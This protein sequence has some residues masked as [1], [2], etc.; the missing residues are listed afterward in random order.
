MITQNWDF[1]IKGW[2]YL[3]I[4]FEHYSIAGKI[5]IQQEA[6]IQASQQSKVGCNTLDRSGNEHQIVNRFGGE[7]VFWWMSGLR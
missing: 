2:A 1:L 6:I 5:D 3:G 4:D 7:G